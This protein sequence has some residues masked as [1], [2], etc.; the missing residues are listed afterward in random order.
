MGNS[1]RRICGV[2][3]LAARAGHPYSNEGKNAK[4]GLYRRRSELPT[5]LRQTGAHEFAGIV[6]ELLMNKAV[7][8]AASKGSKSKTWLD[9]PNGPIATDSV[10]AE[11]NAGAYQPDDWESFQFDEV[12]K[13][14]ARK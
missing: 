8:V 4:S 13:Q 11:L 1:H 12:T 2:N 6:E 9:V 10:G 5:L 14:I 3:T 7:V